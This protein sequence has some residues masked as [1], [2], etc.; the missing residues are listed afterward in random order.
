MRVDLT[1]IAALKEA[2]RKQQG[3][4]IVWME[5]PSNPLTQVIDIAATCQIIQQMTSPNCTI[6]TVVDSTLAPL[7]Q[8]LLHGADCVIHS[9]TKYL[10]GHSDV[11]LGV[12]TCSPWTDR[13]RALGSRLQTVQTAVGG[14]ASSL[15]CWL[16]L[17]GLRTLSTRWERQ[18]RTAMQLA[19]HLLE[20]HHATAVVHYPGLSSHPQHAVARR[21]MKGLFGGMLSVEFATETMAMAVAGA[22]QT[23]HRA[24][25]LGGTETVVEH[26]A[27]IEPAGRVTSPAGLLRIS[28]GL[29]DADDLIQDFENAMAI[30]EEVLSEDQRR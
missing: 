2:L 30:A 28:V 14:V 21:Q 29:E 12:S 18:S 17:R 24:T 1:D 10:G 7:S 3:Q 22:L 23:A 20:Q 27:S 5:T 4:V 8:P 9:A 15:D 26:R 25:S 16:T 13:G 19:E 11:L 6:T